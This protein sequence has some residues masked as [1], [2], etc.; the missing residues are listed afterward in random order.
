MTKR[1]T[2]FTE[3]ADELRRRIQTGVY[4]EQMKLPSDYELADEF[5][6]SRLTIR[7]AVDQLISEQRLVKHRGKGTY[8]MRA[9]KLY[10]GHY[11]LTSFTEVG[12]HLGKDVQTKLLSLKKIK[13]DQVALDFGEARELF[14]IQ[15]L[16]QYNQTAMTIEELWIPVDYLPPT[17]S[18]E[19]ATHS[20][21]QLLEQCHVIGY[22]HQEIA[23]VNIE[24]PYHELLN[25]P[26]HQ[27]GFKMM[28][29][30]YSVDGALLLY[31]CSYYRGDEYRIKQ[32]LQR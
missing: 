27:A 28:S 24:A 32:T 11:G 21:F 5:G 13:T 6:V 16:R 14:V 31:D 7:K 23:A 22:S 19:Q 2:L 10:S 8:V 9:P 20:L 18:E 30:T 1:V 12:E 29:E 3:V 4:S 26:L 25:V 15:R 17:F